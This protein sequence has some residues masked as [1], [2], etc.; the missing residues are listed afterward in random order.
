M[1]THNDLNADAASEIAAAVTEQLSRLFARRVSRDAWVAAERDGIDPTLWQDVAAI[2]AMPLLAPESCG[3]AG[4]GW[5]QASATLQLLGQQLP[6]LPIGETMLAAWAFGLAGIELPIEPV[7]ICTMPL[8]LDADGRVHGEAT[9]VSWLPCVASVLAIA[10]GPQGAELLLL[11]RADLDCHGLLTLDRLPAA[12]LHCNAVAPLRRA[13]L[14]L[15]FGTQGLRA[16]LAVL[17]AHQIAG[18]LMQ[19]LALCIDHANTRSQFGKTIGKFQAIQHQL[20]EL[21]ELTAAV[22]VAAT[23]AA[24]Q[25]DRGDAAST[26]RGAA[27]AKIRAGASATRATAIAHQVFGAIGVTDEHSLHYYTR[28][29][30]Q[31]REDAG[32]DMDW[33]EWLGAQA[34]AESGA[35]LWDRIVGDS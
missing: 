32:S 27:I 16:P 31:W 10:Q 3:G 23:Y 18:A 7:A 22:Q 4:L 9:L 26:E 13:P 8:R 15:A 12:R 14:P 19:V 6:P 34:L 29:L 33:A 25:L 28:R 24:R 21:A 30:W 35:A 17:G 20:A 1:S 2:G 11:A 5:T